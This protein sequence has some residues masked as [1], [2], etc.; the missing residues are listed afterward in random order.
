M[1]SPSPHTSVWRVLVITSL[2]PTN[3]EDWQRRIKAEKDAERKKKTESAEMLHGYHGGVNDSDLKLRNLKQE[4][5]RRKLESSDII[6]SFHGGIISDADLKLKSLKE[7]ERKKLLD[8]QES[9]HNY[10]VKEI[11]IKK[12]DQSPKQ[13]NN[14]LPV[15]IG[16]ERQDPKF[17]IVEGCVSDRVS[18]FAAETTA[19]SITSPPQRERTSIVRETA[20]LVSPDTVAE[21][22]PAPA[23]D[24]D[25]SSL[26][27]EMKIVPSFLDE[28]RDSVQECQIQFSFG[29]ITVQSKLELGNYM[30]AVKKAVEKSLID[31]ITLDPS[32]PP[33]VLDQY[34]DGKNVNKL[35]S[36]VAIFDLMQQHRIRSHARLLLQHSQLH[37]FRGRVGMESGAS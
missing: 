4:E 7:E 12:K 37:M 15:N 23:V 29:L 8:A 18:Q 32:N 24:E 34:L 28:K 13:K 6:H 19:S 27:Q 2:A 10:K 1:I 3:M 22:I 21:A 17:H 35:F 30:A 20:R 31:G 33:S 25:Q 36:L 9:W 14:P 5:R 26:D 11:D 16:R